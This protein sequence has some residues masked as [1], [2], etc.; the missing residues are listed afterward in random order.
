MQK[1]KKSDFFVIKK[2]LFLGVQKVRKIDFFKNFDPPQKSAKK[3]M[4]R[5]R[6]PPQIFGGFLRAFYPKLHLTGT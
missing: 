3:G 6:T 2:C 1:V 4:V 5:C